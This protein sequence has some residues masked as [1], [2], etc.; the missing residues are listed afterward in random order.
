[1][2]QKNKNAKLNG[3]IIKRASVGRKPDVST[4]FGPRKIHFVRAD[5]SIGSA[6]DAYEST[7]ETRSMAQNSRPLARFPAMPF[8][9]SFLSARSQ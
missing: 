7:I 9:F 2:L 4:G 3:N 1:M 8:Q 5:K 6:K